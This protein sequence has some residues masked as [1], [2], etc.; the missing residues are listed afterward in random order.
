MALEYKKAET[1]DEMLML[2]GNVLGLHNTFVYHIAVFPS[3]SPCL[4]R[5][6]H[7]TTVELYPMDM[8]TAVTL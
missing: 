1:S 4:G 6:S 7:E 5:R 8:E 3:M 2:P